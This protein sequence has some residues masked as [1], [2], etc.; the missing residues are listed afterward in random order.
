[1]GVGI[2]VRAYDRRDMW[3]KT[4]GRTVPRRVMAVLAMVALASCSRPPERLSVQG[5]TITVINDTN[6]EWR[7]VE[8][9]VNNHYRGTR[10]VIAPGE[11]CIAPLD[12]FVAGFGQR[13]PR[14]QHVT[15]IEV[16]ATDPSGS[17]V[18]LV[19]GEGRRR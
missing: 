4:G 1:V 13:F 18:K 2:Y 8:I 9:W 5:R 17:P 12:M 7:N 14:D 10:D 15:G 3:S 11:R 19:W 6:R 16:T